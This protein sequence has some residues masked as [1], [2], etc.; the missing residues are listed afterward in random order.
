MP[1]IVVSGQPGCGSSTV[2]KLLAKRLKLGHFSVG[3][4]NKS[5]VKVRAKETDK[6][7]MMWRNRKYAGR[8]FHADSDS[9][10]MRYMKKGGIVVDG[11]LQIRLSRGL[12]DLGVWLKAPG[13]VRARRYA[14]RDGITLTEAQE[15]LNE[16]EGLERKNWLR[17][18][19]FDYFTQEKEADLVIN[20]ARKKPE[21]ITGLIIKRLKE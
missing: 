15:K 6:S 1:V 5:H 18:Y 2:A 17:I 21:E 19:G 20:T 12:Y 4:W 14:K 8:K 7:I 9:L 10:A 13:E 11:K 3:D 16:K